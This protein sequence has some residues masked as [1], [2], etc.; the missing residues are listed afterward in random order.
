MPPK[1]AHAALVHESR[2][3][4]GAA[5]PTGENLP[6][7]LPAD[8]LDD[9]IPIVGTAGSGKTYGAKG[10]VERLLDLGAR[11]AIVAGRSA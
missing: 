8:A 9:R 2:G 3:H 1:P 6:A 7:A 10:F 5:E 4:P 11:V